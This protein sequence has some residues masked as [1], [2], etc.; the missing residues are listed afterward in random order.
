MQMTIAD[1]RRLW[2]FSLAAILTAVPWVFL[3]PLKGKHAQA[4]FI[5]SA[6]NWAPVYL[7]FAGLICLLLAIMTLVAFAEVKRP[8]AWTVAALV[9]NV[10]AIAMINAVFGI[11]VLADPVVASYYLSGHQDVGSLLNQLEDDFPGSILAWL[12]A[13]SGIAVIGAVATAV[14]TW[15][16][17]IARW[18]GVLL[19]AGLP[20]AL[21]ITPVVSW[22]GSA[23]LL[24]AGGWIAWRANSR[25]IAEGTSDL[26]VAPTRG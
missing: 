7:Y 16:A 12:Q 18:S 21:L 24:G 17:G 3:Y 1:P 10:T 14:S 20:L 2:L 8:S 9:L 19:A 26:Q 5:A 13:A 25:D 22:V 6:S 23:L 11:F 15:R 4:A